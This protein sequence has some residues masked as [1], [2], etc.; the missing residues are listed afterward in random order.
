MSSATRD[1][2]SVTINPT[3]PVVI[4]ARVSTDNQIGYRFDSCDHQTQF[5]RDHIGRMH[6]EGWHEVG[7]LV[8]RAYSGGTMDRPGIQA[9]M[10]MVQAGQVKVVLIFKLE[11]VSRNMDEWGPFRAF[12]KKYGCRL[13]SATESI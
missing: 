5:C 4:Y 11:R 1:S 8:D 10:R 12:L 13:E 3:V 9:L 7:C 2:A 6:Q